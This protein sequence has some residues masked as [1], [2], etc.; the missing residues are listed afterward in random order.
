MNCSNTFFA[1]A[2]GPAAFIY[3]V[4]KCASAFKLSPHLFWGFSPDGRRHSKSR[5]L[6]NQKCVGAAVC[7]GEQKAS[8]QLTRDWVTATTSNESIHAAAA[9][10]HTLARPSCPWDRE[11]PTNYGKRITLAARLTLRC[12]WWTDGWKRKDRTGRKNTKTLLL[13]TNQEK[14]SIRK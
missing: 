3:I 8:S 2:A 13:W 1:F 5:G 14:Q 6:S 7:C 10:S 12:K 9:Q 4:L 11:M